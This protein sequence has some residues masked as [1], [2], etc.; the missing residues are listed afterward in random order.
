[1]PALKPFK[2]V[3]FLIGLFLLLLS[4][5]EQKLKTTDDNA[6]VNSIFE[7]RTRHYNELTD[8]AISRFNQEERQHFIEKRPDYFE[9][10]PNYFIDAVFTLDTST[11]VF[12]MQTTTDRKPKYRIF[13]YLV[14][15]V[16]DTLQKLTVYQNFDYKDHPEHG[17]VLFV[18]F[19]DNTNEFGTYGGGRYIDIPI[20]TTPNIQLDFNTAYNPYC[21]Y[22]D[23]WSCPIVPAAN[24]MDVA[25]F[26]GEKKYK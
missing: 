14:F 11:A 17:K 23:R 13:G 26:A 5:C 24:H 12:E 15:T 25:I 8:T 1:M 4:A 20:L 16:K 18:P 3:Y 10:D 22:A 2:T 21:A 9:P 6:Y 7:Q 19:M